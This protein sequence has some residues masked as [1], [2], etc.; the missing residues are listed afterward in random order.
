[1]QET[2]ELSP[3][4][5]RWVASQGRAE[6]FYVSLHNLLF[7][8]DLLRYFIYRTRY[9]L[10]MSVLRVGLH[11]LEFS[12][13]I[14]VLPTAINQLMILRLL[15]LALEGS[16]WGVTDVMRH[17]IRLLR[18]QQDLQS[19]QAEILGWLTLSSLVAG[20]VVVGSVGVAMLYAQHSAAFAGLII[21]IGV[22]TG[23]R[24]VSRTFYSG[25]YAIRRI[26]LPIEMII[27][28]EIIIFLIGLF[29]HSVT[30]EWTVFFCIM[31]STAM[32]TYI[33]YRYV[34]SITDFLRVTP[35]GFFSGLVLARVM[36]NHRISSLFWPAMAALG[37]RVHE[38][39]LIYVL[40]RLALS[41]GSVPPLLFAMYLVTPLLRS[42]MSWGQL[43]YFDLAKYNMDIFANFRRVLERGGIGFS[44]VLAFF[45]GAVANIT[46]DWFVTGFGE[47]VVPIIVRYMLLSA[48]AGFVM[49]SLFSRKFYKTV[50]A[51]CVLQY[52]LLFA[53]VLGVVPNVGLSYALFIPVIVSAVAG[54]LVLARKWQAPSDVIE[55]YFPWLHHLYARREPV[56]LVRLTFHQATSRQAQGKVAR[57]M[58]LALDEKTMI[59]SRNHVLYMV[60]D[61]D[62]SGSPLSHAELLR[63]GGG[64]ISHIDQVRGQNGHEAYDKAVAAGLF[65]I[66]STDGVPLSMAELVAEFKSRFPEGFVQYP[67]RRNK[68]LLAATDS[69]IRRALLQDARRAL[70]ADSKQQLASRGWFVTTAYD[71]PCIAALFIVSKHELTLQQRTA[72]KDMLN[73][74]NH[75]DFTRK[76][77]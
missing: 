41:D 6:K 16:W 29:L 31:T 14:S 62:G 12:V 9:L 10:G 50:V 21:A 30:G 34:R 52:G 64:Y 11:I 66:P 75:Y 59:T 63:F 37:T 2:S 54:W 65:T 45:L 49:I 8:T 76:R 39:A 18:K 43:M 71:G 24:I 19:I 38:M 61:D 26:F 35:Q 68:S 36:K 22:Q 33:S 32:V 51:L 57:D 74:Y 60:T 42:C 56:A 70:N 27:G 67:M 69:D 46:I 13:A 58:S 48:I 28:P 20:V 73:S 47:K 4:I 25:A 40:Q 53:L 17:R 7:G 15:S 5:S 44:F 1:M 55:L 3:S 23:V 77:Q 72:W